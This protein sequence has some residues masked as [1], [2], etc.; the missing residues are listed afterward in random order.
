MG[1]GIE[2]VEREEGRERQRE[3]RG[4]EGGHEHVGRGR[5]WGEKGQIR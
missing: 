5:E 1:R 2:G 4:V 3:R